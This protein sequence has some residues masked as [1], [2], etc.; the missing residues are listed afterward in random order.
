MGVVWGLEEPIFGFMRS[1]KSFQEATGQMLKTFA[2]NQVELR[3]TQGYLNL[4][5]VMEYEADTRSVKF[6]EVH[7]Q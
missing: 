4:V 3:G 7:L 1:W 6:A 5:R 2:L